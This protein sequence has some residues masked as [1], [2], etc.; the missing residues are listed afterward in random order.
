MAWVVDVDY[1]HWQNASD[2]LQYRAVGKP[3]A[4][5]PMKSNGLPYPLE[6]M[7]IDISA[8]PGRWRLR[9]GYHEV[10]A[11]VMWLGNAFWKLTEADRTK[12]EN[13]DWLKVSNSISSVI[14]VQSADKC[15]TTADGEEGELQD[16]LRLL[17]FGDRISK[18]VG[19]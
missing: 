17:L 13:A 7:I 1:H 6:Q 2:P 4:H 14:K 15:F 19:S 18:R 12:I 8:N 9:N 5:L 10:V 11:A 3:Y 16:R